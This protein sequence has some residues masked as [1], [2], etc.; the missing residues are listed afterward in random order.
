MDAPAPPQLHHVP[1]QLETRY[2][3]LLRDLISEHADAELEA[4]KRGSMESELR[5][6]LA[7]RKLWAFNAAVLHMPTPDEHI[8]E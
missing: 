8:F 6:M 1:P 2:A 5:A 3:S 4:D 7:S